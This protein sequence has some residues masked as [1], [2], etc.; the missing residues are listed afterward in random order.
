MAFNLPVLKF[1][2]KSGTQ[3]SALPFI[4]HLAFERQMR[5]LGGA[6][7]VSL[8]IAAGAA[9]FNSNEE[10]KSA[11]YL[12]LSSNLPMLSERLA[13]DSVASF[14]GNSDAYESLANTR[15][16]FTTI[17]EKLNKGDRDISATRG[18]ARKTLDNLLIQW[19]QTVGRLD[20][21]DKGRPLLVTLERSTEGQS[22]MLNLVNQ[23]SEQAAP[24]N[25]QRAIRLELLIQQ[26]TGLVQQLLTS[27]STE[28]LPQMD[29]KLL[30][31]Q[32]LMDEMPQ[33]DPT[34]M[35]LK[36][37][38]QTYQSVLGFISMNV[39]QLL[40]ARLA[41]DR[42]L[43]ESKTLLA[44]TQS[45][46]HAY[47]QSASSRISAYVALVSGAA[48]LILLT[49]I[50]RAYLQES[51]QRAQLAEAINNRNQRAIL[52][53]MN[54]LADLAEGDLT[55]TATV[56]E[57]ITGAIADSINYTTEELRKLVTRVS[58]A[59]NQM[60]VA[61]GNAASIS[62]DLLVA[63]EKQMREIQGAGEAVQLMT[64]S[65][66]EVDSSAAQSAE[67][68]RHTLTVTQQGTQAVRN[69]ITGMDGIREQIQETSKRIKRLGES[70][71]EIGEIVELISDIT[72]QTNVLALN[73]AIQAASA[74]EAGR[75]FSVVAEEVQR[76]AE[77]SADATKQI[78]ALVKTIQSDTQDAVMAMEKSTIGV[79]EGAKLT[80]M[81]GQSLREIEQVSN[82]LAGL[83]N[84]ITVSTQMQTDMASEVAT[85]MADIMQIS[86]QTTQGTNATAGS[87]A[88]LTQLATDLN[89]SVSGFKL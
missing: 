36:E 26:I 34:V 87:V 83:I 64:Q 17:L 73:A 7:L 71:Q 82:E 2:K 22:D 54:E 15:S 31:A 35:L 23:L 60:N 72:E 21:L 32:K 6:A 4:G 62:R 1:S 33:N 18:D 43:D 63:T 44:T 13:K 29:Q 42:I 69:T 14:T 20:D 55:I 19:K 9:Y 24:E 77:R 59:S 12:A 57:D 3:S 78:S 84:S 75:G 49:L 86:E 67:V 74:G 56:T 27:S 81:A 10:I 80:E 37:D 50:L 66:K 52:T 48:L 85:A 25:M 51:R 11:R 28:G 53:L 5:Y 30:A 46:V 88:Q 79:V 58:G 61:T 70:S 41:G 40:P 8:L 38:F 68:A 16:E 89:Q 65:I 39:S 45:L 76:L 47:E